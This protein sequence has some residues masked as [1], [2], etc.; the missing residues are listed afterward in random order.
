MIAKEDLKANLDDFLV[1]DVR[2]ESDWNDSDRKIL[3]A[4]RENPNEVAT[5]AA[6]FPADR[7]VVVYCA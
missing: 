5:W 3:H 2:T 7:P 6:R 1:I 4:I